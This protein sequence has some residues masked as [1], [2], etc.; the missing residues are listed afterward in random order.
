MERTPE[1]PDFLDIRIGTGSRPFLIELK[2]PEQR[3]YEENALVT[4]AQNVKRDFTTIPNGHISISLKK[5][6]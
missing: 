6:M 4:E 3:G 1:S 5:M 2:V